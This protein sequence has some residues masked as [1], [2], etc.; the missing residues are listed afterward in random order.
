MYLRIYILNLCQSL[1]QL[2]T[3]YT[4]TGLTGAYAPQKTMCFGSMEIP[5]GTYFVCGSAKHS[6]KGGICTISIGIDINSSSNNNGATIYG[7]VDYDGNKGCVCDIITLT[8][9][10]IIYFQVWAESSFKIVPMSF[11]ALRIK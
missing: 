10:T 3:V 1:T 5:A 6:N 8:K 4:C 9:N 2:G 7:N 11:T